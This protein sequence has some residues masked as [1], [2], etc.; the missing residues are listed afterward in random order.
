MPSACTCYSLPCR[1]D[2]LDRN[3][4]IRQNSPQWNRMVA[5]QLAS[6][7]GRRRPGEASVRPLQHSAVREPHAVDAGAAPLPGIPAACRAAYDLCLVPISEF[8]FSRRLTS[9]PD[10]FKALPA[11]L[12]VSRAL[13]GRPVQGTCCKGAVRGASVAVTP[14]MNAARSSYLNVNVQLQSVVVSVVG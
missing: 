2:A 14:T 10:A 3:H 1:L 5:L 7:G 4:F 9:C 13:T 11:L 6:G 12:A 8:Q